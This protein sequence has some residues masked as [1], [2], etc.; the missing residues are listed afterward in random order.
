MLVLTLKKKRAIIIG[1]VV[2]LRL[3][4]IGNGQ[5]RVGIEA[6]KWIQVL[7]D[8]AKTQTPRQERLKLCQSVE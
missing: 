2:R 7:R 3:L 5:V 8:N 4:E 1:E 6:P